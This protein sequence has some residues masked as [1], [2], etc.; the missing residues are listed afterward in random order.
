MHTL[1]SSIQSS[2]RQKVFLANCNGPHRKIRLR[3]WAAFNVLRHHSMISLG[4]VLVFGTVFWSLFWFFLPFCVLQFCKSLL[5]SDAR[6]ALH[7]HKCTHLHRTQNTWR[8]RQNRSIGQTMLVIDKNL[9]FISHRLRAFT[10]I[11]STQCSHSLSLESMSSSF[12]ERLIAAAVRL[13]WSTAMCVLAHTH[14]HVHALNEYPVTHQRLDQN[15]SETHSHRRNIR[16]FIL[17]SV[18]R[19]AAVVIVLL[20]A[21]SI[22]LALSA[23]HKCQSIC[24]FSRLIRTRMRDGECLFILFIFLGRENSWR[25]GLAYPSHSEY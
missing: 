8:D 25:K 3:T 22:N 6:H 16:I 24:R 2:R 4:E 9:F 19:R 20:F 18:F 5:L 7:Q 10:W 11:R 12:T 21:I 1:L 15:S 13:T 17:A 14:T 23:P